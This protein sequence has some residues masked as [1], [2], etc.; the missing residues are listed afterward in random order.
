MSVIFIYYLY[1]ENYLHINSTCHKK[2]RMLK[3]LE[4]NSSTLCTVTLLWRTCVLVTL[5]SWVP[6]RMQM[7][8]NNIDTYS[9]TVTVSPWCYKKQRRISKKK[10]ATLCLLTSYSKTRCAFGMLASHGALPA[11][12]TG[13]ASCRPPY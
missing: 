4:K 13:A 9:W 11:W 2:S 3:V 5:S 12:N 1:T 10:M 8:P 7:M 6:E